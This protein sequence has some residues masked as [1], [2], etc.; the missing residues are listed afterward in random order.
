MKY[1]V[2]IGI[3]ILVALLIVYVGTLFLKKS[4]HQLTG[5]VFSYKIFFRNVNGLKKEDPVKIFGYEVGKVTRIELADTGALVFI[6]VF[7]ELPLK[8]DATAEIQIKEVLTGKQL[9]IYPGKSPEKFPENTVIQ[10]ISNYDF[11]MLT[12]KFGKIAD[13]IPEH[14][15]VK[16]FERID[17][18]TEALV[19]LTQAINKE[20]TEKTFSLLNRNLEMLLQ[21]QKDIYKYNAFKTFEKMGKLT[22][23]LETFLTLTRKTL[24]KT[25]RFL[26]TLD[27]NS[28]NLTLT[29]KILPRT[30]E[31]TNLLLSEMQKLMTKDSTMFSLFMRDPK[32]VGDLERLLQKTEK[33]LD[34]IN[35]DKLKIGLKLF[36]KKKK[37]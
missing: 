22:D 20:K 9:V 16:V 6:E 33:T 21:I 18:L 3:T 30:L 29:L 34:L 31:R 24:R 19:K 25:N 26:D 8:A 17:T 37:K 1:K 2:K 13:A 11:S 23:S 36:G 5:K 28:E 10:G 12:S 7:Q 15:V 27:N 4:Y 35:Q 32:I 14:S